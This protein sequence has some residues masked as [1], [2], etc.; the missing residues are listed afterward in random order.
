MIP[1][2]ILLLDL[3]FFYTF[4]KLFSLPQE[5]VWHVRPHTYGTSTDT[6]QFLGSCVYSRD[7][8]I[9]YGWFQ[10]IDSFATDYGGYLSDSGRKSMGRRQ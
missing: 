3:Y 6:F 2:K 10:S 5:E 1:S 9:L 8:K 4:L 7:T